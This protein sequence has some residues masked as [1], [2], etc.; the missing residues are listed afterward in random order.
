LFELVLK[1]LPWQTLISLNNKTNLQLEPPRSKIASVYVMGSR[2]KDYFCI[3]TTIV[4]S[5]S[6][7]TTFIS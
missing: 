2:C 5:K 3:W 6:Y 7:L 1:F 4:C